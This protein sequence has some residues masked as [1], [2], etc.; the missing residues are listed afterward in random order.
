MSEVVM[1]STGICPYCVRAKR[2]LETKGIE[3]QDIRVDLE[4]GLRAT[5]ETRSGRS[6]VPQIWIDERHVGGFTDLWAL[7]SRGELDEWLSVGAL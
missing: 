3:Y 6:S 4:P 7:E 2:L 5:M 1:Y